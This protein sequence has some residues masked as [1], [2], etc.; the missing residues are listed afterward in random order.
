[1]PYFTQVPISAGQTL[2]RQGDHADGLYLIEVGSLRA[3]YSFDDH[4]RLVQETMV[5][6]TVAG[7]LSTLSDTQRNATVVAERDGVLW[8]LEMDALGK[9]GREKPEVAR[10]FIHIVLKGEL[11]QM[12]RM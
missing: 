1:V 11:G 4:R 2:W 12:P 9:L 8:K 6:G 7:D 10:D 3:T 5:A